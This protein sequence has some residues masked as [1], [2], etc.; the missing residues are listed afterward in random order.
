MH[1]LYTARKAVW[2]AFHRYHS[3]FKVKLVSQVRGVTVDIE[4]SQ[5]QNLGKRLHSG[6]ENFREYREI[7]R[8]PEKVQER[9]FLE[10]V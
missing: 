3:V 5:G 6:I 1:F 4:R 7:R 9:I 8:T 2:E 10:V